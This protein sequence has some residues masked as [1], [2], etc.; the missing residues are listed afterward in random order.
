M[1]KKLNSFDHRHNY[2]A[3]KLIFSQQKSP[4]II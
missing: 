2:G 4:E 3:L 1:G